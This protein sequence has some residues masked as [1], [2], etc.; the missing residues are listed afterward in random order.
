VTVP[1]L[2]I[3][4]SVTST[5]I[6]W[7][8][9]TTSLLRP[10]AGLRGGTRLCW[11]RLRLHRLL[12][13]HP[14]LPRAALIEAPIR[15]FGKGGPTVML[16]LGEARGVLLETLAAHDIHTIEVEPT[17][18]K[19]W[20]TGAGNADKDRML[21]ALPLG[22]STTMNTD[23]EVDAW[24]LWHLGQVAING[25]PLDHWDPRHAARLDV[26][27]SIDWPVLR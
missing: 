26:L 12:T 5:G 4:P 2:G 22:V 7:P 20:A 25:A 18:L 6:A 1:L 23:D 21:E 11:M 9:G 16:R 19:R 13:L 14:P 24:H 15:A 17:R 3:D 8:N 10:P 27:T